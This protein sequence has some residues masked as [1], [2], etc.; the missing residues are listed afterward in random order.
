MTDLS[1]PARCDGCGTET[2]G[3]RVI[4]CDDDETTTYCPGCQSLVDRHGID[5]GDHDHYE[6]LE[7]V[8]K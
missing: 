5:P 8:N 1:P 2:S 4:E 3:A 6:L 7:A